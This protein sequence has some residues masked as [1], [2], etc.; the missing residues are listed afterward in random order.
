MWFK[1]NKKEEASAEV[2]KKDDSMSKMIDEVL[3]EQAAAKEAAMK[4]AAGN[5]AG[6]EAQT[7]ADTAARE[8]NARNIARLIESFHENQN[9]ETFKAV[10]DALLPSAVFI[11]MTP[12]PGSENK[13]EKTMKFSPAFVKN[14]DEEK[15]FPAFSDKSQIPEGYGKQYSAVTMP[16]GA[17]CELVSKMP[18]CSKVIINPFTRPFVV[19]SEIVE[20]VAKA[21][22]EQREKNNMMVEF[23]TPEPETMAIAKRTAEWFKNK[24]EVKGA[25]FS[26]MKNQGKV[27][28]TFII[29]CP[30]EKRKE[31]FEQFIEHLKAE[32]VALPIALLPIKGLEKIIS[33]S[34]HIERVY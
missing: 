16:F 1:K 26:K 2:T 20:N 5:A 22:M 23:S 11:P 6:G 3:N 18:D 4:D 13:D 31:V 21:V 14:Q 34:K 15:H 8:I 27:S 17:A 25:Y 29:D 19:N 24:P 28:Y 32:K 30:E 12:V 33:E 9:N 7:A 10:L